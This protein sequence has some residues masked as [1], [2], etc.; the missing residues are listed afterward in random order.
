M[1]ICEIAAPAARHEDFLANAVGVL[2]YTNT[3]AAL[4]RS[5]GAKQARGTT[6]DDRDIQLVLLGVDG[7]QSSGWE[8]PGGLTYTAF[9]RRL[10]SS[11]CVACL[12]MR[13]A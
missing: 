13:I 12:R 10:D 11:R 2:E 4:R 1:Q 6:A 7:A 8:R 9:A 3:A 5:D